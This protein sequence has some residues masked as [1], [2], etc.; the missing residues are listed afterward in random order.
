V[1]A[2]SGIRRRTENDLVHEIDW[3]LF[4]FQDDRIPDKN[5]F[6]KI[7]VGDIRSTTPGNLQ[8]VEVAPAKS[9]PGLDVQCMARTSGSQV[10]PGDDKLI[11]PPFAE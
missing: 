1:Y 7:L 6:P 3:A 11:S 10:R 9:L 2:S 8:P 4:E 5:I